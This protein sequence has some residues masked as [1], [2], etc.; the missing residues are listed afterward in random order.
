MKR[1]RIFFDTLKG[2]KRNLSKTRIVGGAQKVSR[3]IGI[4]RLPSFIG[5]IWIFLP[6]EAR[7]NN[8]LTERET[9]SLRRGAIK[10]G[11]PRRNSSAQLTFFNLIPDGMRADSSVQFRCGEDYIV[12]WGE[13][14]GRTALWNFDGSG[15]GNP[16]LIRRISRA[17]ACQSSKLTFRPLMPDK[18]P[19]NIYLMY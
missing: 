18:R 6:G 7:S 16:H 4:Y 19:G 10:C 15:Y 14:N 2:I 8:S 1:L 12:T 11:V 9:R 3:K 5:I 17:L 13:H